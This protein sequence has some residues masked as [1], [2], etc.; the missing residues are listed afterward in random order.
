MSGRWTLSAGPRAA[1]GLPV[2]LYPRMPEQGSGIWPLL[3]ILVEALQEHVMHARRDVFRQGWV[4]IL[5]N[6][7]QC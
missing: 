3:G 6:S 2:V 1:Q 5:N 7:E 4:F